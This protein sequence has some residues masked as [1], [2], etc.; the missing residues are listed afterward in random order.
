MKLSYLVESQRLKINLIRLGLA[1]LVLLSHSYPLG[2]F[3]GDPQVSNLLGL[4]G[5]ISLGTLA[6]GA[7]FALSGYVITLSA[8]RQPPASFVISRFFRIWPGLFG[9]LIASAF[10][11]MPLILTTQGRFDWAYFDF[12]AGGPVTFVARNIFLPLNLQWAINSG[13]IS[14]PY[15]GSI[16]GSLWTLP[17]EV[18]AYLLSLALVIV[19]RKIGISK[20][21][22]LFLVIDGALLV[23]RALA[24][25][26]TNEVIPEGLNLEMFF[27]FFSAGLLA[28][29]DSKF[30][31]STSVTV[32]A[33]A[34][35]SLIFIFPSPLLAVVSLSS[36]I[37]VIP[38]GLRLWQFAVPRVLKNDYSFGLYI[39][40]FPCQQLIA[41]QNLNVS[42]AGFFFASLSMALPL[43]IASWYLIEKPAMKFAKRIKEGATT[44]R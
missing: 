12:N 24:P 18:R 39:Y 34:L 7:F 31:V 6:V 32:G 15:Q 11:F 44:T 26:A 42:V 41:S 40:G 33:W 13:P 14:L 21:Y 10:V 16:N 17:I 28:T 29:L 43:A 9:A 4:S 1:A 38:T 5:G 27:V 36:L 23:A 3:G 35:F 19:G 20:S 25:A 37:I 22:G 2:G 8:I 30:E